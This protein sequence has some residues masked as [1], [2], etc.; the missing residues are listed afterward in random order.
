VQTYCAASFQEGVSILQ[1]LG[2]EHPVE[3]AHASA[4]SDAL[5]GR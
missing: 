1:A 5:N 2:I 4:G 3:V